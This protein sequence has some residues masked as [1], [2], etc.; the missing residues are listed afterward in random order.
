MGM[1]NASWSGKTAG[2]NSK[3]MLLKVIRY[4]QNEV[5]CLGFA[6]ILLFKILNI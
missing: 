2:N 3:L 5:T 6:L 1:V 4:A